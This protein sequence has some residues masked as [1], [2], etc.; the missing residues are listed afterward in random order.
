MKKILFITSF[1]LAFLGNAQ[2]GIN[3]PN[4]T[5]T[6]DVNGDLTIRKELRT[7]GTDVLKGFAEQPVI[8]CTIMQH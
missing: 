6:L 7:G 4:P 8:F 2:V 1:L 5:N 3:T